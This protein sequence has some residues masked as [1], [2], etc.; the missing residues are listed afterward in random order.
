MKGPVVNMKAV[1]LLLKEKAEIGN[2]SR[3]RV[4]LGHNLQRNYDKDIDWLTK[5]FTMVTDWAAVMAR[6]VLSSVSFRVAEIDEK[7][8]GCI[9]H[10]LNTAIKSC[11]ASLCENQ[12]LQRSFADLQNVK[13][14]V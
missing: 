11:V 1:R 10:Q 5:R 2:V 9:A 3:L 12:D 7:W 13:T 8:M 6:V 4:M 14:I